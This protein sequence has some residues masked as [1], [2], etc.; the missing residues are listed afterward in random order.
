MK[1]LHA[2]GA[3]LSLTAAL[4]AL[5]GTPAAAATLDIA[6]VS[7]ELT[8]ARPA[9]SMTVTN[10][11]DAPVALQVRGFVWDQDS[12]EDRLLP[13]AEV[14]VSPPIFSIAPGQSQ[15]LRALVQG[16]VS[17]RERSYRLLIDELPAEGERSAVRM[18][19]RLSVPVFVKPAVEQPARLAW[20]LA[21][22]GRSIRVANLG[23]SRQRVHRLELLRAD[24]QRL[25]ASASGPYVLAGAQRRWTL[26]EDARSLKPGETL[27][28]SAL[29]DAGRIE[30][31]L[32]V[33]P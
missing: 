3:A 8:A 33:A 16:A 19:L 25:A 1:R 10:R 23:G 27:R 22:D 5:V 13:A 31:P 9:L 11:G 15:V 21:A 2:I 24:C 12:G 32:V 17:E 14:L 6:P 7:H 30:V 4:A 28:V 18:A 26:D 29:T 20:T